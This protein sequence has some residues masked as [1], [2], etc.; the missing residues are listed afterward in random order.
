MFPNKIHQYTHTDRENTHSNLPTPITPPLLLVFLFP[1]PS[2]P[3]DDKVLMRARTIVVLRCGFNLVPII[4]LGFFR[5]QFLRL[6]TL[7]TFVGFTGCFTR[8]P[9]PS[10]FL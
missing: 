2:S 7:E 9:T 4:K 10:K 5:G 1:E 8:F 3:G 6:Y